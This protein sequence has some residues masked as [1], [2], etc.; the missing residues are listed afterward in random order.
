[1]QTLKPIED[2]PISPIVPKTMNKIPDVV[3]ITSGIHKQYVLDNPT[4]LL[5]FD[6]YIH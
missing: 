4:V 2:I 1:M 5:H 3:N 6:A